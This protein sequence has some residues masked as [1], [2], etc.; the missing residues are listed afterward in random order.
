MKGFW[1]DLE[2]FSPHCPCDKRLATKH[3]LA[4]NTVRMCMEYMSVY[5][6]VYIYVYLYVYVYVYVYVNVYVYIATKYAFIITQEARIGKN[7]EM[8][9]EIPGLAACIS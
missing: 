5:V 1:K 3:L 9:A 7:G 6:Y 2:A 8:K 4:F